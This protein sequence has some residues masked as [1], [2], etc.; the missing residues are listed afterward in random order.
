[1]KRIALE[2]VDSTN[3]YIKNLP[4]PQDKEWLL[5]STEFQNCGRG[6][7]SNSWESAKGENLLFSLRILPTNVKA[8]QMFVLSQ[9]MAL[10]VCE[11][12]LSFREGFCIKWPNDIYYEDK[13]IAGILI[14][15]DL[16]GAYI[17]SCT[18]G[19]G[20]NVNQDLFTSDAP[21][22]ISLAQIIGKTTQKEMLLEQILEECEKRYQLIEKQDFVSLKTEY[23][24][25]LY[26][27]GIKY[28]Y[29]DCKGRF[30]GRIID[31][32]SSGHLIIEDL[33]GNSRR[34][35]FKEIEYII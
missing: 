14:E 7:G 6:A 11:T 34:Y 1:M 20:L 9:M 17:K 27:K 2:I 21:N 12:L 29:R 23:M 28:S 8:N 22:P 5:V 18:I 35:E 25:L 31:V 16:S 30:E 3:N 24:S 13:K 19:V 26:R 4:E 33:E 10:A 15:N 32:Q